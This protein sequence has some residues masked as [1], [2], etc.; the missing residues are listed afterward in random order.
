MKSRVFFQTTKP[1]TII[2]PIL[3]SSVFHKRP[4]LF[5]QFL[6]NIDFILP[7]LFEYKEA[8]NNVTAYTAAL[9]SYY[10]NDLS[11]DRALVGISKIHGFCTSS[12]DYLWK[13]FQLLK[14][15]T[16]LVGD[17]FFFYP[18]YRAIDQQLVHA[19][20]PY[21]FC[22]FEYRGTLSYNYLFSGDVTGEHGVSHA[23]DLLYLF[24]NQNTLFKPPGAEMTEADW[25]MV[26]TMVQL[27]TSF[28]TEGWAMS[29]KNHLVPPHGIL[30][31]G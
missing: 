20:A 4:H 30:P 5:E 24:E 29:S 6:R 3:V 19:K 23:D 16:Q 27:W 9:K 21:Y 28:A 8:V 2:F 22:T 13:F 11:A 18:A 10:F 14:N 26:D 25:E 7:H 31:Q 17:S 1:R 12:M 15:F